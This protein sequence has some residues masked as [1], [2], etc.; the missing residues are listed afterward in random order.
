MQE[1][2]VQSLG[3]EN[4]L[5]QKMATH[6]S[7]FAWKIPWTEDP[8][9]LQFMGSLKSQTRLSMHIHTH[10]HTLCFRSF[11]HDSQIQ[12]HCMIGII[13]NLWKLRS[14]LNNSSKSQRAKKW[15]SQNSYYIF[16]ISDQTPRYLNKTQCLSSKSSQ[17]IPLLL[18][19]GMLWVSE[20]FY[21]SY[22]Q[23]IFYAFPTFL[24]YD[25]DYFIQSHLHEALFQKEME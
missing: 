21:L 11:N 3:Q 10:T 18:A 22:V 14:R 17:V 8:G 24:A 13:F 12:K 16:L 9:G 4:P 19:F 6:S 25:L 23:R 1:T 7:I 20:Y 15:S 2:Q 5:E